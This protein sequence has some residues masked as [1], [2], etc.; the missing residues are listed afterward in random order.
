MADEQ[1]SLDIEEMKRIVG[2]L[3]L[4]NQA[5]RRRIEQLERLLDERESSR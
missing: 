1:I 3:V 5:L 4:E 2:G